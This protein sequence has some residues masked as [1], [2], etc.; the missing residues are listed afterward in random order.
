MANDE[1]KPGS[2]QVRRPRA[3]T[4]MIEVQFR[5]GTQVEVAAAPGAAC[6][7]SSVNNALAVDDLNTFIQEHGCNKAER[8]FD[9]ESPENIA[10]ATHLALMDEVDAPDLSGFYV[11]HFPED[12]NVHAIAKQLQSYPGVEHAAPLPLTKFASAPVPQRPP[13][14]LQFPVRDD[15]RDFQ[16]YIERCKVNEAW[17][18]GYTGKG[19][20]IADLDS[21]FQ[22]D[23]PDLKGRFNLCH[24]FNTATNNNQLSKTGGNLEHGTKVAGQIGAAANGKG[25]VGIA[26]DAELW[27]IEVGPAQII[28]PVP[29][30]NAIA[31]AKAIH[32]VIKFMRIETR[33]VVI[34]IEGQ[35]L[36]NGN[37]TQ[38]GM[39]RQAVL[40]AIA[41][42]A[43][44]CVAAGNDNREVSET[45]CDDF[46]DPYC[47]G[48]IFKPAGIIVGA[49]DINDNPYKD[50]VSDDATNFGDAVVV[51]APGDPL[52]DLTCAFDLASPFPYTSFFGATSG[53]TAK[54]AGAIA[55]ML[56][57]NDQLNNCDV[58][59]IFR[60]TG[61]PII[62]PDKPLG[63]LLNCKE[64][65]L[66]AEKMAQDREPIAAD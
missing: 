59:E 42:G 62:S 14:E 4:T 11:L 41:H 51:S 22:T 58:E 5:K 47:H 24:A 35:T 31:W 39:I 19:V 16:W 66:M 36:S 40:S 50:I 45:D 29:Q 27:P 20:V 32:Q 7:F 52:R 25:L 2:D 3:Y 63:R 30:V 23:H 53:A 33:K 26:H 49:T 1:M 37:I 21:G 13:D 43:V 8:V 56:Q 54:V 57:A 18:L 9:D 46:L 48:E 6:A 65:V 44:V 64:A 55:L 12:S 38:I 10:G 61:T 34:A 17:D 28:E 15:I 60:Q